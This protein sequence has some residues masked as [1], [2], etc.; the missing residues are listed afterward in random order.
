MER[1]TCGAVKVSLSTRVLAPRRVRAVSATLLF[2]GLSGTRA[3]P[4]LGTH[5]VINQVCPVSS[6]SFVKVDFA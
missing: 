1:G 2:T 3:A 4:A 5:V 6:T